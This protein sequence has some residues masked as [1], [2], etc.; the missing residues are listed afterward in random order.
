M[1]SNRIED[2]Q[3]KKL[4]LDDDITDPLVINRRIALIPASQVPEV[5]KAF[6]RP[7][8]ATKRG[9][10]KVVEAQRAEVGEA[11]VEMSKKEAQLADDLGEKYAPATGRAAALLHQME[12]VREGKLRSEKLSAYY[13]EMEDL[14][15]HDAMTLVGDAKDEVLH[16]A[17]R[18]PHVVDSYPKLMALVEQRREAILDGRARAAAS[19]PDDGTAPK[20]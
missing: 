16:A 12:E 7:D 9:M 8:A 5:D 2:T 3:S 6:R 19:R 20:K 15:H 11:L 4:T 17:R 13:N 1:K 10:R 14:I 18:E